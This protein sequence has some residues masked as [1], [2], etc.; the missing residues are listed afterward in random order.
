MKN[1]FFFL[2]FDTLKKLYFSIIFWEIKTISINLK[3][4]NKEDK[5]KV[6]DLSQ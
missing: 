1:K 5:K 4:K 6:K 3:N 2:L